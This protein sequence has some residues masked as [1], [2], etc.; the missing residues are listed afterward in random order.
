M[1]V[2][3]NSGS[4]VSG[5]PIQTGADDN[6]EN[7]KKTLQDPNTS[8]QETQNALGKLY[9]QNGMKIEKGNASEDEKNEYQLIDN[10]RSGNLSG[11]DR[12]QFN[13]QL[14]INAERLA[15]VEKQFQRPEVGVGSI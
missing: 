3:I 8:T 13:S 9:Q 4:M 14:G 5:N 12:E 6:R 15:E 7:L 11:S 2:A 1:G 10:L